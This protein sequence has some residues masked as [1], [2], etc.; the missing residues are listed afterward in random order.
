M[1]ISYRELPGGALRITADNAGRADLAD[2]TRAGGY[3]RAESEVA[4]SIVGNGL[5][6]VAPEHIGALTDAPII[7]E[8]FGFTDE[9]EPELSEGAKV[10]WFPD[11]QVRDPWA[12]LRDTG[13]VDFTLAA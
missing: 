1:G 5:E 4:E 2:A 10:W 8:G 13:R 3:H 9:G 12:L 6:F 11:Y 7:A